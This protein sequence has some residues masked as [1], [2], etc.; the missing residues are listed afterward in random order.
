MFIEEKHDFKK[1]EHKI[2]LS[3]PTMHDP[4][5]DYVRNAYET[6]WMSTVGEN[7][8][9]GSAFYEGGRLEF[10]AIDYDTWN[11]VLA[12]RHARGV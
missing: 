3:S 6:N 1:F 10:I 11:M 5:L 12:A 8:D 4:E 2:W 7:I 9:E